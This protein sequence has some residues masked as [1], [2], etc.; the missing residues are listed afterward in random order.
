MLN[1]CV[2]FDFSI[3]KKLWDLAHEKLVNILGGHCVGSNIYGCQPYLKIAIYVLKSTNGG[4]FYTPL[5][6]DI[7]NEKR[8]ELWHLFWG[9]EKFIFTCKKII[10]SSPQNELSDLN[11][12]YISI[13]VIGRSL[14]CKYFNLRSMFCLCQYLYLLQLW[15]WQ[16]KIFLIQFQCK[17]KSM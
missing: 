6:M 11:K 16:Q 10:F 14:S 12:T 13:S 1:I 3:M 15:K 8:L 9:D 17:L 2:S 7:S 4:L 5:Y